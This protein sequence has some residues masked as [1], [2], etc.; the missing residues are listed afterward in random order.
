MQFFHVGAGSQTIS[1][2][3]WPCP[4]SLSPKTPLHNLSR[5]RNSFLR[6]LCGSSYLSLEGPNRK[7]GPKRTQPTNSLNATEEEEEKKNWTLPPSSHWRRGQTRG[8][9]TIW[10]NF[11]LLV[12]GVW[13]WATLRRVAEDKMTPFKDGLLSMTCTRLFWGGL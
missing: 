3:L 2:I 1:R 8:T 11:A 4:L 10:S 6:R 9:R 12:L 5:I 13:D 7:C